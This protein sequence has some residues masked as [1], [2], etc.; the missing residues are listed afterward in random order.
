MTI[1]ERQEPLSLPESPSMDQLRSLME[2][3]DAEPEKEEA[4]AESKES[5]AEKAD[6]GTEEVT[7][8]EAA[9]EPAEVS[10]VD[11]EEP[12]LTPKEQAR[13]DKRISKEVAKQALIDRKIAEA[14]STRKAKEAEL[15]K[16]TETGSDPAK[17]PQ[18][19]S[20]EAPEL[21][22]PETFQGTVAELKQATKEAQTKRDEY[23]RKKVEA[24]AE[25]AA[26]KRFAEREAQK[27][28]KE[29]W[30]GAVKEHGETF[31]SKMD[32]LLAAIPEPM[33]LAISALDGWSKVAVHL[34]DNPAE[35][36]AMADQ[37]TAHHVG[38]AGFLKAVAQLGRLEDKLTT[39]AKE[40]E[41]EIAKPAKALPP[42]L[43][44]VVKAVE[45]DSGDFDL[46]NATMS[47]KRAFLAREGLL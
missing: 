21:P 30:D 2:E 10:T 14:V 27:A 22:D 1:V 41:K 18:T 25:A 36:K 11:D 16:L 44:K 45:T 42:P 5:E 38:S 6:T 7:E 3:P 15:A 43:K 8:V 4:K 17:T 23:F 34:A 24:A 9:Q 39:V 32:T 29:R 20:D 13:L 12:E 40:P 26:E 46:A 47:Q 31:S 19:E 28:A 37:F 35:M 33:Q